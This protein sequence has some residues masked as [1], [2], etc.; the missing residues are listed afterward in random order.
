MP[1]DPSLRITGVR[2][3]DLTGHLK[4]RFGWSLN[5]TTTRSVRLVEVLTDA[6]LT[7][8]GDGACDV[9]LLTK[10]P[11]LVIGRSPFEVEAIYND[12]RQPPRKQQR[13]GAPSAPGLD[14][15]LWDLIGKA[16]NQPVS[17]LLGARHRNRITPYVTALY[18]KDWPDLNAGLA[19]EARS[20]VAAGYRAMKMKIGYS[21]ETDID[22]VAAVR[23]AIGPRFPLG[24][25]SNCAY[26]AGTAIRLGAQLERFDLM[27]WEEPLLADDLD[28][29]R[30]LRQTL[31]IPFASGETGS[32]DWLIQNYIQPHLVDIV[33]PD[34]EHVGLTG[35]RLLTH[36][37][38]LNGIRI[39]PHNWGSALRTAATLHWMSCC[40]PLT[41]A[42]NPPA[43]LF[44]FDQTE[45][46]FRDAI[47]KERI[48]LDPTDGM[49]PVPT[50][51]G[52]GVTVLPE[53][54]AKFRTNLYSIPAA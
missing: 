44:E 6:G 36:L 48:A 52:L 51:P 25:D 19:A 40:P 37:C 33:Q 46:P 20:W 4:E 54:V 22:A 11:E 10:H 1:S 8:W 23:D 38:W 32:A 18:R 28:G 43:I 12:L 15:A 35:A 17:A 53:A 34:L 13:P 24:V 27:W 21:P 29:Y 42:L 50:G 49:V 26:D 9:D 45:H 3:H 30:A 7:G 5:W 14:T 39:V 31:R 41:P 2:V 47:L 16:L